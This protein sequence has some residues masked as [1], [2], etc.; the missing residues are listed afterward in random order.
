[1][2]RLIVILFVLF[3][4]SSCSIMDDLL[5]SDDEN[6]SLVGIHKVTY[7]ITASETTD[8]YCAYLTNSEEGPTSFDSYTDIIL[9]F[10]KTYFIN[11]T[12][13][14]AELGGSATCSG[15]TEAV[16]RIRLYIDDKLIA[17]NSAVSDGYPIYIVD[18]TY[19]V[20]E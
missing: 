12:G 2:K 7:V 4:F 17:S 18:L 9:P 16:L 5:E 13:K 10:E 1:M 14:K 3:Q 15:N 6:I 8:Y 11:F 20:N 19:T